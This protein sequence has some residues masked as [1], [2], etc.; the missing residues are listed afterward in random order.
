M[1]S[2]ALNQIPGILSNAEGSTSKQKDSKDNKILKQNRIISRFNEEFPI[3]REE[4]VTNFMTVSV[5]RSEDTHKKFLQFD[6]DLPGDVVVHWGVCK[7]D[8]RK[9]EIPSTPHPPRTKIFRH[10][11]LQTLLQVKIGTFDVY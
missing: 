9:W 10:K 5:T 3:L 4:F 7:A 6:T 11:A 1:S 8:G 2:G